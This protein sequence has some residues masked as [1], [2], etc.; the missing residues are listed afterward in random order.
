MGSPVDDALDRLGN[1]LRATAESLGMAVATQWFADLATVREALERLREELDAALDRESGTQDAL[2]DWRRTGIEQRERAE[3]A[4]AEVQRYREGLREIR[5]KVVLS[6]NGGLAVEI[7][8]MFDA[9]LSASPSDGGGARRL[10][11]VNHDAAT[12]IVGKSAICPDC[13][14]ALIIAT[15]PPD[16]GGAK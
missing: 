14:N 12:D 15:V 16:G 1:G 13:G 2:D 4:E 6:V 11:S 9:L 3:A 8:D 7:A 5:R 10:V